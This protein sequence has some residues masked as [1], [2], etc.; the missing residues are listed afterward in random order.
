MKRFVL[1]LCVLV[2]LVG[3][4]AIIGALLPAQHTATRA[5]RFRQPPEAVWNAITDYTK[6]P[7]WRKSVRGVEALPA[8]N[9][10]PSWSEF[11][12]Y[13]HSIPYE[14]VEWTPP[15]RLTT[16]I[17]DPDLPFGGTWTYELA[18]QADGSTTLR[19]TENGEIRNVFFRF[20]ARVFLGYTKTMD[21]Y[22]KALGEK[23]GEK[24]AIEN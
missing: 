1:L 9:G 5:A 10:K 15:K 6:F 7:E 12:K 14:I 8:V 3:V 20:A 22:L 13:D 18:P 24:T 21:D 2:A 4:V 16:R 19:I 23:F 11:D 17:A